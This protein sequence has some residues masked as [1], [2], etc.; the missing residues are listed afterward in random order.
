MRKESSPKKT[1]KPTTSPKES[2]IH[3]KDMRVVLREWQE[4]LSTAKEYPMQVEGEIKE[5]WSKVIK[6]WRRNADTVG[7][8]L[9]LA[10][11]DEAEALGGEEFRHTIERIAI[12][13]SD[14]PDATAVQYMIQIFPNENAVR[15][16]MKR[17][18][19]IS[20]EQE[21]SQAAAEAHQEPGKV[22]RGKAFLLGFWGWIYQLA[23]KKQ[24]E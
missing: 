14:F 12:H 21:K 4:L 20:N 10:I 22:E 8:N 18:T 7:E 19:Q 11:G 5:E 15:A 6:G 17:F 24:K 9:F 16:V 13:Y 2:Q 23:A 3:K 1:E